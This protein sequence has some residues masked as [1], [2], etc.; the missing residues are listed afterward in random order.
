MK[1][2]MPRAA[3]VAAV[4]R[5][6]APPSRDHPSAATSLAGQSVKS[7]GAGASASPALLS[8]PRDDQLS[9]PR[10]DLPSH[11]GRDGQRATAQ[12]LR[13]CSRDGGGATL[14]PPIATGR[15]P[16]RLGLRVKQTG[17]ERRVPFSNRS[18]HR[19]PQTSRLSR[20]RGHRVFLV[21]FASGIRRAGRLIGG[22]AASK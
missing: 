19:P 10:R 9:L 2:C 13:Q 6:S 18:R 5:P 15:G 7:D 3:I 12:S 16:G 17:A 11:G 14:F 4:D 1:N 8:P 21:L 22:S 20:A